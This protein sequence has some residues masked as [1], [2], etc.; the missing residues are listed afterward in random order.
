MIVHR[1]RR[2]RG[3]RNYSSN[4]VVR[5]GSNGGLGTSYLLCTGNHANGASS[6]TLRGVK[7]RA[8]DH[9][10]LGIGDVCRATRPRI[11]TINSIVNCPDLTSTT[12]SRKHVTTRTLMGNRT[13]TRLVRSVPA[14]VCAVPRVDSING[15]RRR[16]ATVGIPCRINHTR[17]G[18]L[19]HTRVINVGINAL[20][21]LFRQRAG[22]VLNVRYFN[23]HTTRVVRVNRTVVRR[24]NNNGAVRCFIGAAFGCPA[25][26]RTC[27]MTTL[28]N[29]GHLFWRFVRVTVRSYTSNLYRLLVTT[30][31]Q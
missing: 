25:V 20:G 3:V 18:R 29:L 30:T 6:L 22:R 26:T 27:Q 16:L 1:G 7:L 15:A 28:G 2:C 19:T 24:G 10:R 21:V 12:C 17:F 23:R 8:S 11:C 9:K 4:I 5:L 31:R 13:A 14:N